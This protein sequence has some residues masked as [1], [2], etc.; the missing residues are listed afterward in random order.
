MRL[1]SA[2]IIVI[3][4]IVLLAIV[5]IGSYA[6]LRSK[7]Q[8]TS[9]FVRAASAVPGRGDERF[10]T[11]DPHL[12]YAHAETE[13]AVRELKKKFIWRD[14]FVIY[15]ASEQDLKPPTILVL[16][17]STSD[18]VNY[19]HSWPEDLSYILE[20]EGIPAT[21]I[22]GATGGYST[23]QELLKLL[24]DGLEFK[25]DI[26]ISY[27]GINDRGRYSSLPYPMVHSYQR[28]LLEAIVS[29]SDS[30]L[31][32][33]AMRLLRRLTD[34]EG[35]SLTYSYGVETRRSLADQYRRNMELMEAISAASAA[36]FFGF[37]QPY[38]FYNSRHAATFG[39]GKPNYVQS[40]LAL[41]A[42][43]VKLPDQLPYMHDA[44]A[45]LEGHDG[46]YRDAGVH[47]TPEGDK[48]VA[49]YIFSV[50]RPALVATRPKPAALAPA[51]AE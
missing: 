25:P 16:G 3:N 18:G 27:S 13:N 33:N 49:E 4:T 45:I 9:L 2:A 30:P 11:L 46:V 21:V 39:A 40:V 29:Q 6:Y 15:K 31:L 37:I 35:S 22:N 20:R 50:V 7:G 32:P 12:G 43:I 10:T 42:E 28:E 14:G 34:G 23:N 41:Y 38:G 26:V 24:R 47:L 44:T 1:R 19:G 36:T 8:S 48:I 51:S 5:E 17:G